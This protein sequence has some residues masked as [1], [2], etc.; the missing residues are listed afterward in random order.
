[1]AANK[2]TNILIVDGFATGSQYAVRA[3]ARGLT[4]YHITSGMEKTSS[5]P[6]GFM[7]K[8]I[9]SQL[10]DAYEKCF[11]MP[12]DFESAV[13]MLK[14]YGFQAVIPGTETGV[15][16]AEMLAHR[17]GLPVNNPAQLY[18]RRDK[19]LMQR[20]LKA[21]GLSYID[22][23]LTADV[24]EAVA[25]Y[26]KTGY[27]RIIIKPVRSAG[28]DGVQ[29]CAGEEEIRAYFASSYLNKHDRAGNFNDAL[30][31]Q[32]YIHG[33]EMVV[34]CV[35]RGGKH[36]LTD[37]LVYNKVLT[38]G[39]VPIYEASKLVHKLDARQQEAVQYACN[40]LDALGIC[41]GSSHS[42]IKLSSKGP[43]LVETGA[44]V[45]GSTPAVYY[46]ALGYSLI[47]WSLDA[48]LSD[49]AHAKNARRGYAPKKQFMAKFFISSREAD[50]TDVPAEKTLALLPSF[51]GA[52]FNT[53]RITKKLSP[54]VDMP[55]KP[56]DCLLVADDEQT[57][58]KDYNICRYLERR[59]DGL[60]WKTDHGNTGVQDEARLL[61]C[62]QNG[63]W[64][65][66]ESDRY[67]YGY[68]MAY[69]NYKNS[70][71]Y[72]LNPDLT[73]CLPG[74]TGD[75]YV[76][77]AYMAKKAYD[78]P[79]LKNTDF[80]VNPFYTTACG[81]RVLYPF[82]YNT[83]E[84]AEVN[85][86]GSLV[87]IHP[88]TGARTPSFGR[89]SLREEWPLTYTERQ[90]VAEQQL[91][92]D[93]N[94]YNAKFTF[95]LEGALD[96]ARLKEALKIWLSRYR[97]FR[98]YYPAVNG[99]FVHKLAKSF[100]LRMALYEC[101][102]E[103]ALQKI[104]EQNKPYDLTSG[105]LYRFSLFKTGPREHLFH[106]N[107]HHIIADGT[108]LISIIEE[109]WKLYKNKRAKKFRLEREDFL[110]YAD[111]QHRH[112]DAEAKK[113]FFL[114]LFKDGVPENEMPTRAARPEILPHASE[115][116]RE[117]L[118]DASKV[119]AAAR[120][121]RVSPAL[122]MMMAASLTLAKYC[123]SE[124]I[125]LGMIMNG[126][127]HPQTKEMFGMFVNSV[128]V[129]FK[130]VTSMTLG[131]YAQVC[132]RMFRGAIDNQTCP[133]ELLAPL[134]APRRNLSRKPV[135]DAI[136]NYRGEIRPYETDGVKISSVQMRQATQIDL[137]FEMVRSVS[138][139]NVSV[140]YSE[141]LYHPE[142]I[143]SMLELL[144]KIIRSMAQEG[145][146]SCTLGELEAL[147]QT[148]AD[149]ILKDFAGKRVHWDLTRTPVDLFRAQAALR[150]GAPA[151]KY[152]SAV[153]SYAELDAWSD[154]L[155]A[156]LIQKGVAAG[157]K[158]GLLIKRSELMPVCA[159]GV[160][161]ARA[162]YVPLDASHP[163][164]RLQFI[165]KDTVAK[166][167]IAQEDLLS[168]VGGY[169]GAAVLAQEVRALAK[170]SGAPSSPLP[171]PRPEDLFVILY[172][173]GTTGNPKG[174]ML[175]HQ[176]ITG[177]CF[178]GKEYF[179][180]TPEDNIATCA[181]FGFDACLSDTYPTLAAGAC[182]H[183]IAEDLRIDLP[184]LNDYFEANRVTGCLLTT[185]LG[186]QFVTG[187]KNNSLRYLIVGGETL[188][189]VQP[190]H[191]YKLY[192]AYGPTESTVY[193]AYFHVDKLYD[194]V[195]L[196]KPVHNASV[197]ITDKDGRLAPVGTFGELCVSGNH[198]SR[199]YLNLPQ[200]TAARFVKNPFTREPGF[201]YMYKT[202]DVARYT[203]QGNI[204]FLGRKD[205]QV[206]VRGFRIE[207]GEIESCLRKHPDV[208][209]CTVVAKSDKSGGNY[210]AAYVTSGK[211]ADPAALKRFLEDALPPFM[212][213]DF[214]LQ[215]PAIP[216]N[217]NG[218]VD[219][220]ALPDPVQS[221]LKNKEYA[222]PRGRV[223]REL[224]LIWADILNLDAKTV[225][226]EDGFFELGGTSLRATELSLRVRDAFKENM[227][228]AT[229]FKYPKLKDQAAY[230][231]KKNR[232]SMV[233]AFNET[234]SKT[235]I[236]FVH[237]ANTGAEAYVPLAA[238]LP[239]DQPFYA[240][241]PHNI[242]SEE[243]VIR[244]VKELASRYIKYIRRVSPD[245]PYILG[246]WSFGAVVAY[247]MA[248]QLRAAG[249]TVENLYL[250][251]PIIE[252][253]EKEKELTRKLMDTSFFQG[254][255]HN[256]PLFGRFQKL[257]FAD[258]LVENN[259][260]VLED[261]FS[262]APGRYDGDVTLFKATR[263]EAVPG[264]VDKKLARALR[265]FQILHRDKP[266]NG[267]EKYVSRLKTV[268]LNVLHNYMMR[269]NALEKIA[270]VICAPRAKKRHD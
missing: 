55:S 106:I 64:P 39:G 57:L 86:D 181:G 125:A 233:Y 242:F 103:E 175:T 2:Q 166:V 215:L 28:T 78:M 220:A 123:G 66:H 4:P 160:L 19:Y 132:A 3:R 192:N 101:G 121:L 76:A 246:G 226:R 266:D 258:K 79:C 22:S 38:P 196:G 83:R 208:R 261:M 61:A 222:A 157:D 131:E 92:P 90:M 40:V 113:A 138:N 67:L 56:G 59:C 255:L 42:E 77:G 144:E 191:G 140:S 96:A 54:T 48:Y 50:V 211:T 230:L 104:E 33:D 128:P 216:L 182:L 93:S 41:Y 198:L 205:G 217:P 155:A 251:D 225:G 245:G 158:V 49:E 80:A 16:A 68:N 52:N 252:H 127:S 249:K 51:A 84:R 75:I 109:L 60:L 149:R 91:A 24:D 153:L 81:E 47:D 17:F 241:E 63:T 133:F 46:D 98:S 269:G 201:E 235:P 108:S 62:L 197:Y 256:D 189:P 139:I 45:M 34:N 1:M 184:A 18:A 264:D 243:G 23:L 210:V 130:P 259:K 13:Q 35:S 206:K 107:M 88:K 171:A 173:S 119:D 6:P 135:F 199:G 10:G 202:G 95:K 172:T 270:A 111:F 203:P 187:I 231:N 99:K 185:Q 116:S 152:E 72:V 73:P 36:I 137:Q 179:G 53:L 267:F 218:K 145:S 204:D 120:R 253:P 70:V 212:I 147:P 117:V 43:V 12:D 163:A 168:S 9:A 170:A 207:L 262:Y 11:R 115:V 102:F 97:I 146:V 167:I 238:K 82:L 21:A 126:R 178:G 193:T 94:A 190:P 114:E 228:P 183:V 234:G 44:R 195:P 32:E 85:P 20:T 129:R 29:S 112:E 161:K 180:L 165:L 200:M 122:F 263:L 37:V 247:E 100:P 209:D 74:Q 214:I 69:K 260:H 219:R 105:P 71:L 151:V 257:G 177:L 110:D 223:E 188:T 176:N 250:L 65:E 232:F 156:L 154:R 227:P 162:A 87:F 213:P 14:P 142:I 148:Q 254:Y 5:F 8:Y 268:R 150:P 143:N 194:R 236:F 134:L 25:W 15:I 248:V 89:S 7:D 31:L 221:A 58:L 159:L 30:L 186:R 240:V 27:E 136:V 169:A 224:A 265:K 229:I 237:T 141:R 239:P 174:V 124:D 164:Q 26:R 118:F 244:G